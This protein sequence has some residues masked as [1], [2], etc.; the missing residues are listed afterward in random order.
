MKARIVGVIAPVLMLGSMTFGMQDEPPVEADQPPVDL[1]VTADG[2]S[3]WLSGWTGSVA[4]GLTGSEGNTE[5]MSFR[6]EAQAMRTTESHETS[7]SILYAYGRESSRATESRL[8][9]RLRNDWLFKDSPWRL[10]ALGRFEFDD[11]QD[12]MYRVSAFA[13]PAYAFVDTEKT[14]LLGRVGLGVSR[15]FGGEDNAWTPEG[16][17]GGDLRHQI[18]DRQS[19]TASV[20]FFPSLK[21]LGP[22]RFNAT[23]AW[24]IVVD[25]SYGLTLRVGVENRYDST[26]GVG[27]KRNDFTYFALLAWNF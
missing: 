19:I 27:F 2:P 18:S 25:P 13:G 8:D 20:D 24:E 17:I 14:L 5:R 6:A 3:S 9:A 21:D 10:F 23:A 11:F 7:A 16:L 22:Y 26:P 1:T 15:E 4:L 12:W